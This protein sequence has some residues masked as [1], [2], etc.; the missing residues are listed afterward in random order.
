M[1]ERCYQQKKRREK[2]RRR[3]L[4]SLRWP[5]GE[6]GGN[7]PVTQIDGNGTL[8]NL[9]GHRIDNRLSNKAISTLIVCDMPFLLKG[10][11]T[12]IQRFRKRPW[13]IDRGVVTF[14]FGTVN[15]ENEL[16]S[17]IM[18]STGASTSVSNYTDMNISN[19]L[20]IWWS[21]QTRW[22]WNEQCNHQ[23]PSIWI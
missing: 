14:N 6:R 18:K 21:I 23:A 2:K 1:S 20:L 10:R 5:F 16:E 11:G 22:N 12:G 17:W 9:S 8:I 15:R 19:R 4:A 13:N 3:S 7:F